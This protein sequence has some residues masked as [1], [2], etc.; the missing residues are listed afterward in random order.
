[1]HRHSPPAQWLTALALARVD[2]DPPQIDAA[3]VGPSLTRYLAGNYR[4]DM[5][6]WRK[7]GRGGGGEAPWA[8]WQDAAEE[9]EGGTG[10]M[11]HCRGEH[12]STVGFERDT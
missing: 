2:V 11:Q 3:S 5:G 1:V 10:K 6:T 8:G 4:E 7:S 12:G 9:A